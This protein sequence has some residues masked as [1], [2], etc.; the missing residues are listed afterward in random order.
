MQDERGPMGQLSSGCINIHVEV[1]CRLLGVSETAVSFVFEVCCL[2][3][4]WRVPAWARGD[5]GSKMG[6]VDV[7][8]VWNLK[9]SRKS[10]PGIQTA[11][12]TVIMPVFQTKVPLWTRSRNVWVS[13]PDPLSRGWVVFTYIR[14]RRVHRLMLAR[15]GWGE[16]F[17]LF[18]SSSGAG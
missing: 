3:F 7:E 18:L 14:T 15:P 8:R 16:L 2:V 9:S 13:F 17:L 6:D 12:V 4:F 1:K 10:T 5:T 11:F